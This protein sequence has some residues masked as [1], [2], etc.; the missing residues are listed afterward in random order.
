[1]QNKDTEN[2]EKN[3]YR[4]FIKKKLQITTKYTTKELQNKSIEKYFCMVITQSKE[5]TKYTRQEINKV[6]YKF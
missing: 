1:M 6:K 2:T 3:Y 5:N 4:K